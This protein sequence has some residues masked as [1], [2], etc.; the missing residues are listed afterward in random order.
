MKRIF[1]IDPVNDTKKYPTLSRGEILDL[2]DGFEGYLF[3]IL[4]ILQYHSNDKI[5]IISYLITI[6]TL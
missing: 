5:T 2:E 6:Y 1:T 3:W 4:F